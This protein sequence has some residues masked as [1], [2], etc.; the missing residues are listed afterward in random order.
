M[1]FVLYTLTIAVQVYRMSVFHVSTYSSI[2]QS[3]R[4][5]ITFSRRVSK[6]YLFT[7]RSTV[8]VKH[9]RFYSQSA[10]SNEQEQ[11]KRLVFLG[12]PKVVADDCLRLLADSAFPRSPNSSYEIVAVVTQPP[13]PAGQIRII[14]IIKSKNR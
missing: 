8:E 10:S 14:R 3:S 7:T 9:S 4:Q 13:A 11:R 6:L 1:I 2:C 5:I 12:T